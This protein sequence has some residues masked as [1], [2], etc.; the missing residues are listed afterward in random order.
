MRDVRSIADCS[1]LFREY[2]NKVMDGIMDGV[3]DDVTDDVTSYD[4]KK[5][6]D[7]GSNHHRIPCGP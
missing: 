2:P 3:T 5:D 6:H 4:G 7:L 1:R